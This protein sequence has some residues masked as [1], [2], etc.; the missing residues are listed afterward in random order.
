MHPGRVPR[1]PKLHT[2]GYRVPAVESYLFFCVICRRS[3]NIHRVVHAS[4]DVDALLSFLPSPCR[5]GAFRLTSGRTKF[6][7]PKR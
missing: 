6:T 3:I 1:D 2:Y 7:P 4:R 5:G